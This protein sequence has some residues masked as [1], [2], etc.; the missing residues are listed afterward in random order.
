MQILSWPARAA[1]CRIIRIANNVATPSKLASFVQER[2]RLKAKPDYDWQPTVGPPLLAFERTLKVCPP[3]EGSL[4][5]ADTLDEARSIIHKAILEYLAMDAPDHM[6]LVK[7]LPGTGK[8]TAAVE[9]VDSLVRSGRRVAYAGPRHDLFADVTAKS[10]LAAQWY[11]WLPRQAED[12]DALKPQTCRYAEQIN[13][14]L[15]RGYKGMDFC[16]APKICGWD[17]V[18]KECVYHKQKARKE[19]AIYIQHQHVSLGHPLEFNVLFGD[20]NPISA[21]TR[22]WRIPS[23]WITPPGMAADEPLTEV[24]HWIAMVANSTDRPVQGPE[25]LE[26]CGGADTVLQ[27][28][29]MYAMPVNAQSSETI[30]R[31]EEVDEK[32]YFHLPETVNLLAREARQSVAGVDYPYRVI[33]SPGAMTLLTRHIPEN[34]PEHIIWLDGTGQQRIY[35][36]LFGRRVKVIDGQPRLHGRIF[37]VVDR[38]N[39]KS[40]LDGE[41]ARGRKHRG[42]TETLV[43]SI[44]AQHGY[45][46][47]VVITYKDLAENGDFGKADTAHFYAAR[48][49]NAYEDADAVIVVGA[50]Q[51][52]IYDVVKQAKMI[53][54]ERDTAFKVHWTP[55]EKVYNFT[56]PDGRGR[57]YPV[58]GFWQDPDLQSVLEA[59]R[60]DEIIQAAHRGRP[61]N[62]PVDIWLVTNVPIWSLPPDE[63]LTMRDILDAPEGVDIFK[64]EKVQ[65]LMDEK[66]VIT[67]GDIENAGIS[68]KTA[69]EYL[70]IVSK[71]PGW[72]PTFAAERT[73][74]G[75]R[76][77]RSASREV[78]RNDG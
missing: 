45:L 72:K 7:S 14:W 49:T 29:E 60:E 20:E 62:K 59:I 24:L 64:W 67:I 35:E 17:Y 4:R 53:F 37:Q 56:D 69:G 44:I 50:P 26:I 46:R 78:S 19:G 55:E 51:A 3:P 6:L 75:G 61:V 58:S 65:Q 63:L 9:I 33:V 1:L 2:L 70:D 10:D 27:A 39:G 71:Q 18:N 43:Q 66:D 42:Q 48:G 15:Q 57:S 13:A 11:E 36:K 22:E 16:S 40:S 52:N 47:P 77:K 25:L 76:P 30:H 31:A 34:L 32:P 23:K 8:T 74:K 12:P 54:F 5:P 41:D 68:R 28:C 73:N 38:A 21:F